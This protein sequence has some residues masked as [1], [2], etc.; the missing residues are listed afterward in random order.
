MVARREHITFPGSQGRTLSGR[1]ELPAGP[2]RATALFAHCF[3]CSSSSAAASRVSTALAEAGLAVMRFDFTG[4]GASEGDF[5]DTNFSTSVADLVAASEH[6]TE[7]YG[8]PGLL[9]GHSLGGAA[10]LAAASR[11]HTVKAVVTIGAPAD[12]RHVRHLLGEEGQEA[13]VRDGEAT[14][15]IGG[16]PFTVKQHFLDDLEQQTPEECIAG[17]DAALLVMH[18]PSDG[19][20]GI[21]NAARIYQA[22]RHP[23]SFISLDGADHLLTD[24]RD[25]AFVATMIGTWVE[26]YL[27]EEAEPVLA[28]RSDAVVVAETGDGTF[29]NQVVAGR[30]RF[31]M[32]EPTSVGGFDA[33]PNPYELL[34]AAL[35]GC[36]SMTL[37]MY[38]ERKGI[39]L[40]R[41]EVEVHHETT[42]CSDCTQ[43]ADGRTPQIDRWT[44]HLHLTGDLTD[45]QRASLVKI[46]DKCPVHRTLERSSVVETETHPASAGHH[47]DS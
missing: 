29:L 4:L 10:V 14:V 43:T 16:R 35:G 39:P 6:L 36:T 7:R 41:V 44:R 45:E 22:A 28:G 46:A 40:E 24:R 9:V 8:A 11:L 25:A 21:D 5:E 20:V 42:H 3:T 18:S 15:D 31:L 38:A 13:I 33:G 47:R 30:H 37:R 32:D 17:L 27:E 2:V 1:I 19:T 12:P 26:R 23:K 34:A